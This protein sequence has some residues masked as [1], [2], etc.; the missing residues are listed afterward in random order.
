[1]V[2]RLRSRRLPGQRGFTLLEVIVVMVI[3]G[4]VAAMV[5]PSIQAGAKQAAVRRSVRAFISAARQAS[6][7]AVNTR[8]PTSLVVWP[9]DGTFGVEG[10]AS[11]YEL[12]DFAE[13][14]EIIGGREAEADDEIRFDFYPTGSS[15]GGSVEIEFMPSDRRQ[16]YILV[17]DPL[18]SRVRIEEAS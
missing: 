13:F 11:R 16:S 17:L 10:I 8:K 1:M 6:A 4:V 9:D 18:I 15:A 14:G 2:S 3:V 7:R 5:L 12:P